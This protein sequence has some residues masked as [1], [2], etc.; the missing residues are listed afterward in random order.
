MGFILLV[1]RLMLLAFAR[2][3][4]FKAVEEREGGDGRD[5]TPKKM[6]E[7]VPAEKS[8]C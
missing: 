7:L 8:R 5:P 2:I 1:F 6:V 4:K 3:R